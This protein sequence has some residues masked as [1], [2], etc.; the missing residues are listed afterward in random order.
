MGKLAIDLYTDLM[1]QCL[2]FI[3]VW[4]IC[5]I[6]LRTFLSSAFGGRFEL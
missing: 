6:I 3:A 4:G 2:P 5:T 1:Q